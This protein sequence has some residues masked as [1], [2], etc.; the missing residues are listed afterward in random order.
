MAVLGH[1][2]LTFEHLDADHLLVILVG[3]EHLGLLGGDDRVAGNKLGHDATDGL[4]TEGKRSDIKEEKVLSLFTTLTGKDTTLDSGTIGNSL[5]GVD[6]LVGLFTTEEFLDK[7]LDLGDT[8]R[9]TNKH[10][11][12]NFVLLKAGIFEHTLDGTKSLLEKIH[13]KLLK[14]GTGKS[15]RE[16]K[17]IEEVLNF[18]PLL[19]GVRERALGT[20]S[21][22][23]ELLD[24]T[25]VA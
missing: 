19:V 5:I 3:R 13:V 10:N 23:T 20:F 18:H 14:A 2:P 15:L 6:T 17:A 7:L 21:L 16:V 9:T 8:S 22:T 4:N 1:G 25:P 24:S 12:I 11:L